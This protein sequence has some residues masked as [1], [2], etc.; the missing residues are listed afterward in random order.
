[1]SN[2]SPFA[3]WFVIRPRFSLA[4]VGVIHNDMHDYERVTA[5]GVR[6][7]VITLSVRGHN[8]ASITSCAPRFYGSA[9]P[10]D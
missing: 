7:W 4:G 1:L 6:H 3:R 10:Q 9:K 2:P 5:F 8:G